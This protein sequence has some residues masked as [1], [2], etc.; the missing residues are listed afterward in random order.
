MIATEAAAEGI[1]LQFCSSGAHVSG[2]RSG[3]T[4]TAL[5]GDELELFSRG[6]GFDLPANT[7]YEEAQEILRFLNE[8]LVPTGTSPNWTSG[9]LYPEP[10]PSP[11]S[12]LALC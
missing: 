8:K 6:V 11:A 1:N 12:N 3:Y 9:E 7:S 5:A 4:V 10:T 2:T